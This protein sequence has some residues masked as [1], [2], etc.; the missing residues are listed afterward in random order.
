MLWIFLTK[1]LCL[2]ESESFKSEKVF[3]VKV[4]SISWFDTILTLLNALWWIK[5]KA[6]TEFSI[7][8][9]W[10]H[11]FWSQILKISSFVLGNA[12]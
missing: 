11:Q 9:S 5:K 8:F 1:K 7:L 2:A 10:F 12:F 3:K 4:V 6:T